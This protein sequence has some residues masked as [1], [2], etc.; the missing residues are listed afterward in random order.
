[1]VGRLF[2]NSNVTFHSDYNTFIQ[3]AYIQYSH[4]RPAIVIQD[5][6]AFKSTIIIHDMSRQRTPDLLL[7]F[8][9]QCHVSGFLGITLP[10]LREGVD[11]CEPHFLLIKTTTPCNKTTKYC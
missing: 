6:N 3:D 11:Y 10:L 8:V 1:M 2:Q 9:N 7:I 4:S 5:F